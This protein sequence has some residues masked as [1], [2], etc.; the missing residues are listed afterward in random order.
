MPETFK[1]LR[2]LQLSTGRQPVLQL[3]PL[4]YQLK[5]WQD[6]DV[7]VQHGEEPVRSPLGGLV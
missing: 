6:I 4:P 2:H 5:K 7:S 1:I 3:L